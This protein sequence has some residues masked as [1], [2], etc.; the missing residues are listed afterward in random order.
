M[1]TL[2]VSGLAVTLRAPDGADDM[3]LIEG[4]TAAMPAAAALLARLAS[5]ADG[6]PQDWAQLC[7]TDFEFLLLELRHALLGDHLSS[8]VACPAC[9]ERAEI[10][11]N[12]SDYTAHHRP[13]RLPNIS[14]PDHDGW[15]Q[16]DGQKFRLPQIAD[17]LA[18]QAS[19]Q[20]AAALNRLCLPTVPPK[21]RRRLERLIGRLAPRLTGPVGGACPA[22][23]TSL[24][25]WFDV[26]AFVMTELRR[27]AAGI[28]AEVHLIAAG[29]SWTEPA[30]LALPGA[31]RRA[32]AGLLRDAKFYASA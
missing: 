2:P 7:I 25:A 24:T 18:V 5:R 15:L 11:F 17:I 30:I 20:P 6:T 13:A 21:N 4:A 32:Y 16:A 23:Q 27:L 10:S 8:H 31:R 28:Y 9:Q 19:P 3:A 12:I 22:C 26:P 14:P 29:Y 1:I